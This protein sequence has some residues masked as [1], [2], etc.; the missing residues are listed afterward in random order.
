MTGAKEERSDEEN[1]NQRRFRYPVDDP[2]GLQYRLGDWPNEVTAV[3]HQ[4]A[5][6][7][8]AN[9]LLGLIASGLGGYVAAR[10]AKRNELLN[11]AL[12]S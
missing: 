2:R 8:C 4:H 7:Y 11:A 6:L 12:S 10:I 1:L 9:L 5:P 3:V